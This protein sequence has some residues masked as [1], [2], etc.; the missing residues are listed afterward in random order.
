MIFKIL[1]SSSGIAERGKNLSSVYFNVFDKNLIIDAGE[2]L[3][4][5]IQIENIDVDTIDAVLISHFHPDHVS[6]LFMMIQ[7]LYIQ[8]RT[9]KLQIFI[10][11]RIYDFSRIMGMF[12]TF[13]ER[14]SFDIEY[15]LISEL[16]KHYPFVIYCENDHLLPYG[17]FIEKYQ[18]QNTMKSYSFKVTENQKSVIYTADINSSQSI[19]QL[20]SEVDYC[21]VDAIHP[22]IE[23]IKRIERFVMQKVLLTHGSN[24]N[25][26]KLV[27]ENPKFVYAQ[28]NKIYSF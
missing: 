24:E 18:Y 25:T 22:S 23:E 6:G 20:L 21:I 5:K 1:G 16:E 4:H 27:K 12:Y 7:T 28:E 8:K 17:E 13:K 10:P 11:E 2:G 15:L 3:A 19:N 14:L 9:K 26:D